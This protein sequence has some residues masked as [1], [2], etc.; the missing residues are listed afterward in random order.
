M[1]ALYGARAHDARANTIK[2]HVSPGERPQEI[3]TPP[4]VLE[5]LRR[6]WGEIALDPCGHPDA[7]VS[8]TETWTGIK[9]ETGRTRKDGSAITAWD[10]PGLIASWVDRT[11]WNP[12][13]CDLRAWI[14]KAEREPG[15]WAG[16]FPARTN[17]VWCRALLRRVDG[18]LWL[19]PLGFVGYDQAHPDRLVLAYR[20]QDVRQV[21]ALTD[22]A[23]GEWT[24]PLRAL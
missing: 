16:L 13:F 24:A 11:Y 10:G 5:L 4:I 21:A 6:A 3:F 19:N 17:R 22:P 9:V 18:I 20:G 2:A 1:K 12:P 7:I 23:L 14:A 15:R 8:A